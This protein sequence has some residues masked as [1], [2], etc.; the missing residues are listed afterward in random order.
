MGFKC[1]CGVFAFFSLVFVN[2]V[3]FCF[4]S[5]LSLALFFASAPHSKTQEITSVTMVRF[6]SLF[7]HILSLSVLEKKR[8]RNTSRARKCPLYGRS[9]FARARCA[10]FFF[11]A[12]RFFCKFLG[13]EKPSLPRRTSFK[14][15]RRKSRESKLSRDLDS[16]E[17]S[18]T[19]PF[20]SFQSR[21]S[22]AVEPD[23]RY[24][25]PQAHPEHLR[26]GIRR[27]SHQSGESARATHRS[28]T[29]LLQSKIHRPHVRYSS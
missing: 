19:L 24:P 2:Q 11:N 23:E 20:L 8:K 4:F 9:F 29:G 6:V 22:R 27:S 16:L 21:I 26:R 1:A 5:L 7:S 13:E 25:H 10:S 17:T 18:L 14:R 15:K 12:L 3:F 28:A